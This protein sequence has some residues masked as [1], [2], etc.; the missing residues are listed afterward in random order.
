VDNGYLRLTEYISTHLPVRTAVNATENPIKFHYFLPGYNVFAESDPT[1][2]VGN[3][4]RYYALAPKDVQFRYGKI[5]PELADW[6][7]DHG[8]RIFSYQSDSYGDLY[9][10]Q[11]ELTDEPAEP[12]ES[13]LTAGGTHWR[14]FQPAKSGKVGV[15]TSLFLIWMGAWLGV[16]IAPALIPEGGLGRDETHTH[17]L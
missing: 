1:G 4:I 3:G 5:T 14:S 6:I 12:V 13:S 9:L 11:V 8:Q 10:Y 7:T 15:F 2:A 17:R 16:A